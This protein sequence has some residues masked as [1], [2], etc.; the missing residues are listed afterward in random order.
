M[1]AMALA[2]SMFGLSATAEEIVEDRYAFTQESASI[3]EVDG[4]KIIITPESVDSDIAVHAED[5]DSDVIND[6][7]TVVDPSDRVVLTFTAKV[8]YNF[9][10]KLMEAE[11]ASASCEDKV[12]YDPNASVTSVTHSGRQARYN[13]KY[14]MG[15]T[16]DLIWHAAII[17]KVTPN[18]TWSREFVK[19]D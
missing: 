15:T 9:S 8:V 5:W 19:W 7:V 4:Y 2:C 16:W 12:T 13:L 1:V 10:K 14:E 6:K 17:Y 18:G 11:V 3:F